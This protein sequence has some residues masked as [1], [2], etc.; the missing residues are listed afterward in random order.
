LSVSFAFIP[1]LL[2]A[3]ATNSQLLFSTPQPPDR[4]YYKACI[5]FLD[6]NVGRVLSA[7]ERSGLSSLT[8]VVL[9]SDHG[10]SLGEVQK[11][12]N[13]DDD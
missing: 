7:L 8:A 3:Q 9:H 11:R 5:S 10:W 13:D 1:T 4:L 6:Y 2:C 12:E